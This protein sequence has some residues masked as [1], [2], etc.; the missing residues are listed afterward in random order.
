MK[1]YIY[2]AHHL[3]KYDTRIEEHELGLIKRDLSRY[4][5]I[6]PNGDIVHSD[7]SSEQIIMDKCLS[8]I[9]RED[10]EGVVFSSLNGVVGLGVFQEVNYAISLNKKIYYIQN[11]NVK[12]VNSIEFELTNDSRRFYAIVKIN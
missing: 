4:E 2:Y 11:N 10:V 8:E 9:S 6:N 12:E 3:Y 7:L 5:I 1:K